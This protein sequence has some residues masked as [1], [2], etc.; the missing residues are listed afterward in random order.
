MSHGVL[1]LP[2]IKQFYITMF[3]ATRTYICKSK[4]N[5]LICFIFQ[6]SELKIRFHYTFCLFSLP[7]PVM[8]FLG[9]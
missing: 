4:L 2:D 3:V 8:T 1:F 7:V 5:L 6:I 9:D